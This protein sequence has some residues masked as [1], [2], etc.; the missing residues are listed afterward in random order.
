MTQKVDFVYL[1]GDRFQL[2]NTV[3]DSTGISINNNRVGGSVTTYANVASLP[4]SNL[5]A[6]QFA[7]VGSTLYF[8]N[9]SG[10]YIVESTAFQPGGDHVYY[11]TPLRTSVDPQSFA[12]K[13]NL[14]VATTTTGI[15]SQT[16]DGY[17]VV[18][19]GDNDYLRF[20]AQVDTI[21]SGVSADKY[22]WVWAMSVPDMSGANIG[23]GCTA[24][25]QSLS[26]SIHTHNG[27]IAEFY[28]GQSSSRKMSE[29]SE[30]NWYI[31]TPNDNF[32]AGEVI[33]AKS[34]AGTPFTPTILGVDGYSPAYPS[35]SNELMFFGP[36]A[37]NIAGYTSRGMMV[38]HVA[39]VALYP[40][41]MTADERLNQ[42]DSLVFGNA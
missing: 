30:G 27:Y 26:F 35:G 42:F 41:D 4:V 40:A 6:G 25:E 37:D 28:N 33:R 22:K 10:W 13:S 18:I 16:V 15:A 32:Q 7:L 29:F 31:M 8:T 5:T 2:G 12:I 9:G 17:M 24:G 38:Q 36:S 14:N 23:M 1:R 3:I 39:G 11:Y 34:P 20:V 21:L 19:D